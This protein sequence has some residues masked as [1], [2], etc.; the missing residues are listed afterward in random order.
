MK[1][2]IIIGAGPAGMTAAIYAADAGLTVRLIEKGMY[3]GQMTTTARI[4]NYP[5]FTEIAGWD[6]SQRMFECVTA[7]GVSLT[8]DNVLSLERSGSNYKVICQK[9][10]YE[11]TAVIIANGVT[12]RKLDIPGEKE[13]A[14]KGVSYCAVCDGNFFRGRDV[15]VIGG[16]NSALEDAAY[17]GGIC[18]RV[19]LI[20][21]RDKFR[22]DDKYVRAI[23]SFDNI[24]RV[25]SH[26]PIRIIGNETLT[27]IEV[28]DLKTDIKRSIPV[29]G[30]F[31]ATGLISDNSAYS[32]VVDLTE[33]GYIVS[34]ENCLTSAPGVFAAGDTRQKKL[35]Q[36][37][38]ACADGASAAKRAL[39]YLNGV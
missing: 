20:H 12:R 19:Y 10:T 33:E 3:G 22:A 30:I 25:L 7:S 29:S 38:M 9:N 26:V 31:A 11:A 13:F 17:L 6:L 1:E 14:G 15:A 18:R 37:V 27:G 21:R 5:G 24:E 4:E 35:R 16:G 39:E 32:G 28:K 2:V 34:D 23:D 36:I 8:T